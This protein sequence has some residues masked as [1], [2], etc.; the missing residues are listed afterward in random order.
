MKNTIR[1]KIN[2]R[3]KLFKKAI[4]TKCAEDWN[5]YKNLRNEITSEL[6]AKA[7]Y[8]SNMFGVVTTSKAY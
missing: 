4:K 8:F 7:D 1:L 3:F 6:R 5:N 2:R